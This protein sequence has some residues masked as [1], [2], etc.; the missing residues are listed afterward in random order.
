MAP[1]DFL[2]TWYLGQCNGEWEHV[3]GVTIET[4]DNPGWMITVDLAGTPLADR[5][6]SAVQEERSARD[7]LSCEVD[8]NQFRGQGDPLKLGAILQVF[9]DWAIASVTVE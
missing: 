5:S 9:Q 8:H 6:M 1:I 7:W 4:L 2:Q 3:Q